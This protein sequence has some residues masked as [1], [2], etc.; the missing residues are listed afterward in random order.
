[1]SHRHKTGGCQPPNGASLWAFHGARF[2]HVDSG[3]E[4]ETLILARE[5]AP[6]GDMK[7]RSPRATQLTLKDAVFGGGWHHVLIESN[8]QQVSEGPKEANYLKHSSGD[9]KTKRGGQ[10]ASRQRSNLMGQT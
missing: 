6:D 9:H 5:K 7:A 10:K 1:M 4:G 2:A 3:E 8:C